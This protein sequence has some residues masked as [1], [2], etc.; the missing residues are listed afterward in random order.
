MTCIK[1]KT[2]PIPEKSGQDMESSSAVDVQYKCYHVTI[3][4]WSAF[5]RDW[6]FALLFFNKYFRWPLNEFGAK[7][8]QRRTIWIVC[9]QCLVCV[10][11]VAVA[12]VVMRSYCVNMCLGITMWY[13]LHTMNSVYTDARR[14]TLFLFLKFF[15]II[16]FSTSWINICNHKCICVYVY[17]LL[18]NRLNL[19][20][21]SVRRLTRGAWR[22]NSVAVA[23]QCERQTGTAWAKGDERNHLLCVCLQRCNGRYDGAVICHS[24]HSCIDICVN[25]FTTLNL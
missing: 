1:C 7:Y 3:S 16:S 6:T 14:H 2:F 21:V 25:F 22:M 11:M 4:K 10:R 12:V 18:K 13:V 9:A 8:I 19:L 23:L 24:I 5:N 20:G 15:C 17:S